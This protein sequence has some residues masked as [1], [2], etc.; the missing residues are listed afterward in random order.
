MTHKVKVGR[1]I[2]TNFELS[3]K[4]LINQN[5]EIIIDCCQTHIRKIGL[6]VLIYHFSARMVM[7]L[8]NIVNYRLP[9]FCNAH[10]LGAQMANYLVKIMLM[11]L[12]H[13]LLR[14]SLSS[15]SLPLYHD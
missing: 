7:T 8:D 5:L 9:R 11:F 2:I 13:Y 1:R 12:F 15:K 6:Q 3:D 14:Y 10:A 4:A